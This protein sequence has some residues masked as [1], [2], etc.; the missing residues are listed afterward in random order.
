MQKSNTATYISFIIR[1][2]IVEKYLSIITKLSKVQ[3]IIISHS[4][5]SRTK[6]YILWLI[7]FQKKIAPLAEFV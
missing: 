1:N 7:K 3:K 2:L 5:S 6:N 4:N